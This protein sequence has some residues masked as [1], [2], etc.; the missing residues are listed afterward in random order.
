M[1]K[2]SH[3]QV[4]IVLCIATS[5]FLPSLTNKIRADEPV[6][7]F[8][9]AMLAEGYYEVALEYLDSVDQRNLI[10]DQFRRTLPFEKA[11]ILS[12]S[13]AKILD[14]KARDARLNEAQQILAKFNSSNASLEELA[15]LARSQG[16]LSLNRARTTQALGNSDRLTAAE[17]E[18]FAAQARQMLASARTNYLE[19][20]SKVRELIDPRSPKGLKIDPQDPSSVEKLKAYQRDFVSLRLNLALAIEMLADTYGPNDPEYAQYLNEAAKE[21]KDH[22]EDYYRDYRPA[23]LARLYQARCY[24]KLNDHKESLIAL[25]DIFGKSGSAFADIKKSAF[26]LACDSWSKLEPYPSSEIVQRLGPLVEGLSRADLRAPDWLRVQLELAIAHYRIHEELKEQPADRSEAETARRKSNQLLRFIAKTPSPYRDRARELMSQWNMPLIEPKTSGDADTGPQSF[27]DARQKARDS[28]TDL[29]DLV[30][31]LKMRRAEMA[32]A[33]DDQKA[34]LQETIT[35]LNDQLIQLSNEILGTIRLAMEMKEED[36]LPADLNHLRY[37]QCY[38]Y[39][40]SDRFLETIV[41]GEFM[42]DKFSAVEPTRQATSLV[43]QSYTRLYSQAA[44]EDREF[45]QQ[46]MMRVCQTVVDRWPGS[47]EASRAAANL[48]TLAIAAKDFARAD[49]LFQH[50]SENSS[51]LAPLAAQLGCRVWIDYREKLTKSPAEA[52]ALEAQRQ[53]A[54]AYLEQAVKLSSSD[55]LVYDTA[56]AS[57]FLV[58]LYLSRGETELAAQALENASVAPLD[59]VKQ[60]HPV[61][62]SNP[63]ANLFIRDTYRL[64][65]RVYL[66]SLKKETN[67]QVAIDKITGILAALRQHAETSNRPEDRSQLSQIYSLIAN[68][69]LNQFEAK[70][71][72]EKVNF[73]SSLASFLNSIERDSNDA[74]TILWAGSTALRV[75][76]SLTDLG[77]IEQSKPMFEQAVSALNRAE[78]LGFADNPTQD[79]LLMELKRQRGLALRGNL[80]FEEAFNQ[81]CAVLDLAPQNVKVQMDAAETLQAWGI[82]TKRPRLLAEAIKGTNKKLNPQTKRESNQVWGW[83]FL[84]RATRGKN[85]DLFATAIFHWAECLLENGMLEKDQKRIGTALLLIETEEKRTTSLAGENWKPRFENLKQRIKQ[86]Q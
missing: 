24:Q 45:E 28:V 54:Q 12:A 80:K 59:L 53:K 64:A 26:L 84:A 16:N 5:S 76:N 46:R 62:M 42:L 69:I 85:D 7:K 25:E 66:A 17:K 37:L 44:S 33:T 47:D 23:W 48:I 51:A 43:I 56:L 18:E 77:S 58:D 29:E 49:T 72:T 70:P 35:G 52:Q 74:E 22:H 57:R 36:T 83:E 14:A 39:F 82:A 55:N 73:A 41:I 13:V 31:E 19:A 11:D 9:D 86:N 3:H 81:F 63:N 4:L 1:F 50:V 8:L 40:S 67:P 61:I 2:L 60:K 79:S 65:L 32:G 30:T 21:Y 27:E 71:D 68:E 75:A 10:D 34:A 15:K 38:C 20:R 78:E 6:Q